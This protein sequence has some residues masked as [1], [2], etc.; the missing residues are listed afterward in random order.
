MGHGQ[1]LP[2]AGLCQVSG[3]LGKAAELERGGGGPS[4]EL[5]SGLPLCGDGRC[6]GPGTSGSL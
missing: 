2:D 4:H 6:V 5:G 1:E 3:A